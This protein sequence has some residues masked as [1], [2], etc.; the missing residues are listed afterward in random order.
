[1]IQIGSKV[2]F[3][4]LEWFARQVM[5]SGSYSCGIAVSAGTARNH[6][7]ALNTIVRKELEAEH[8]PV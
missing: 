7:T 2:T 5:N 4:S 1:M 3:F 6:I 8:R